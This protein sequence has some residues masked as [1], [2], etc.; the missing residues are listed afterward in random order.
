MNETARGPRGGGYM[1]EPA[2]A[3]TN[4]LEAKGAAAGAVAV[5]NI[6]FFCESIIRFDF[7]DR[8][9]RVLALVWLLTVIERR[10]ATRI[11]KQKD[12]GLLTG[13]AE[14][15]IKAVLNQLVAKRVL[16]ITRGDYYAIL[17]DRNS[18]EVAPRYNF[19]PA[20][21]GLLALLRGIR[22]DDVEP[23]QP[24]LPSLAP[25]MCL[26]EALQEVSIEP[27]IEKNLPT[28][29]V[30][31]SAVPPIQAEPVA[32]QQS[33]KVAGNVPCRESA[34]LEPGH[35]A[36]R[37]PIT[38]EP[39]SS[40]G[41][42]V[43]GVAPATMRWSVLTGPAEQIESVEL[44]QAC[45]KMHGV[46]SPPIGTALDDILAGLLVAYQK[47]KSPPMA[48]AN[49]LTSQ[50]GKCEPPPQIAR[51]T[52]GMGG[53]P[54]KVSAP[55]LNALNVSSVLDAFKNIETPE[56]FKTPSRKGS[57]VHGAPGGIA[58]GYVVWRVLA[59][60]VAGGSGHAR[61]LPGQSAGEI[62]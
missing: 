44:C 24:A 50:K 40:Q 13:I 1:T 32:D 19:T 3:Q 23:Y 31:V 4:R 8:E 54:E 29:G 55:P 16:Q 53:L 30:R 60:T 10:P 49:A 20:M 2:L 35:Q 14:S 11:P 46:L 6:G 9:I 21:E 15:H 57:R 5:D 48:M 62:G 39:L 22:P 47:G 17:A 12:V 26:R 43:C 61:A 25:Q 38:S 56:T 18:W 33:E 52:G 42:L 7:A 45:A 36:A 28:R 59:G 51:E 27:H 34:G 58:G 41:C 37:G